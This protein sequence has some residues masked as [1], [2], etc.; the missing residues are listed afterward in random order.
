[1]VQ[2]I[3]RAEIEIGGKTLSFEIGRMARL[4]NCS[5]VAQL[6][7]TKCLVATVMS[8]KSREGID[9]L[10]LMVNFEERMYAAGKIPGGF[11]K[12]EGRPGEPSVLASRVIDRPIRPLF[13]EG[14]RNDINITLL[15]LS[16]DGENIPDMVGLNG[17]TLSLLMSD[18]QFHHTVAG[19][20][21][22]KI[23]GESI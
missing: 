23:D 14:I 22:A 10:P 21:I 4:T 16:S 11:I 2:E 5:V 12:R 20:R 15:T 17:A 9:F 6:G 8:E 3:Q 19:V 1:M 7:E 13:P 18:I